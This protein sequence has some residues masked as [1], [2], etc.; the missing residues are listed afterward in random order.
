MTASGAA[1]ARPANIRLLCSPAA[2]A[3]GA[4]CMHPPPAPLKICLLLP[5]VDVIT[6]RFVLVV[7]LV[8]ISFPAFNPRK[9]NSHAK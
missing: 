3:L 4:T 8:V 5:K 7:V 2:A 1:R 6:R 9:I